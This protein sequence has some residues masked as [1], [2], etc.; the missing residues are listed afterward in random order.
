MV[1]IATPPRAAAMPAPAGSHALVEEVLGDRPPRN[2]SLLLL[3][4]AAGVAC[5]G[6]DLA[7]GHHQGV[8]RLWRDVDRIDRLHHSYGRRNGRELGAGR[9]RSGRRPGKDG[10]SRGKVV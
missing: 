7:G 2:R 4:A 5:H 9:R 8:L 6:V 10:L 1:D 3:F